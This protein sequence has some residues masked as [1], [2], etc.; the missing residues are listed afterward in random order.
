VEQRKPAG[1]LFEFQH[2]RKAELEAWLVTEARLNEV[3]EALAELKSIMAANPRTAV[4]PPLQPGFALRIRSLYCFAA[5][6]YIRCFS[7]GRRA[8]LSIAEVQNLTPRNRAL[9]ESVRLMRNQHLA[10]AV[11]DNEGSYVYLHAKPHEKSPSRFNV[12]NVVLVS[13][14]LAEIRQFLSLVKK[15]RTFVRTQAEH[16][17]NEV[18]RSVF[19]SRATWAKLSK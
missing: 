4:S 17:G 2:K 10:H 15:V 8:S 3:C 1:T 19:G 5:I 18:A 7:T 6:T 9:H 14:N 12:I 11:A 13:G 16:A